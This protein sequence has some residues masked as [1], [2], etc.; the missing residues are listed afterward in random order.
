[1]YHAQPI[2]SFHEE[3]IACVD[4]DTTDLYEIRHSPRVPVFARIELP[5]HVAKVVRARDIGL[6]GIGV[7]S[8]DG[9]LARW[10]GERLHLRF[11]LPG[12]KDILQATAKI[13]AQSDAGNDL[14]LG[15]RFETLS[16]FAATRI[17]QLVT[18]RLPY[19]LAA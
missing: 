10:A 6:G 8:R 11:A 19:R 2:Y 3:V 5:W 16:P 18:Q 7:V 12:T 14:K 13:V 9:R 17:Y 1:M 4:I 15:L